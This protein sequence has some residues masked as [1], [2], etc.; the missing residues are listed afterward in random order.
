MGEIQKCKICIY[1]AD[2]QKERDDLKNFIV[3]FPCFHEL[4]EE[5]S[6]DSDYDRR[7]HPLLKGNVK[8]VNRDAIHDIVLNQPILGRW[9]DI[10]FIEVRYI[11]K[12]DGQK[13]I[14]Y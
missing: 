8:K 12:Q 2:Y 10:Y 1:K 11:Q 9:D 14:Y 5:L 4:Y 6:C 13:S 7:P 3:I